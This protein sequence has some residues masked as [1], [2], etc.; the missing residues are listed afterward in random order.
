VSTCGLLACLAEG[1]VRN[2]SQGVNV[3]TWWYAFTP[4]GGEVMPGDW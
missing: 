4:A 3:Q 1:S 2:V